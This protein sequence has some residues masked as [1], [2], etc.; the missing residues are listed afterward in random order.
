V[1]DEFENVTRK[2][3]KFLV[4]FQFLYLSFTKFITFFAPA[5]LIFAFQFATE[6]IQ[7]QFLASIF[8][9]ES[10]TGIGNVIYR[11][12]A[13]LVIFAYAL[14]LLAVFFFS[15][16]LNSKDKKYL[17]YTHLISTVLG[18]FTIVTALVFLVQS[19][20]SFLK[21]GSSCN[22]PLTQTCNW[23]T[24]SSWRHSWTPPPPL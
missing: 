11:T 2:R 14:C 1:Q 3:Q 12:F 4:K 10:L 5:L 16:H 21:I 17:Y 24:S 22:C 18:I 23:P 13:N 8:A 7:N 20:M 19:F 15:I 9:T 6:I